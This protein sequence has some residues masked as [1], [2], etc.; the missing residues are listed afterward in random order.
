M[1]LSQ[2]R[3]IVTTDG[4][5]QPEQPGA[6]ESG[7]GLVA[8]PWAV[9]LGML[10][11]TLVFTGL[12]WQLYHALRLPHGDSA[13][14]EEHLW[15][16]LHGKGFR[17]FLDNGRL[18]LGEHVQVVHLL[19]VPAYLLWPS[20]LLLELVQGHMARAYQVASSEFFGAADVDHLGFFAVDHLN[21]L[22]RAQARRGG[23]LHH[24]KKQHEARGQCHGNQHPVV[25]NE[26][27]KGSLVGFASIQHSKI[28]GS[29]FF[30]LSLDSP[31]PCTN[32]S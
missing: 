11:Y 10:I 12:N 29:P 15:N 4:G 16:L 6:R 18:F 21:R 22:L 24:G 5:T 31:T 14:Y 13:M 2:F 23:A 7:G 25:K 8:I 9:W 27:Q 1:A 30:N 17:S 19:L 26:F 3:L 32:L 28:S 20:H